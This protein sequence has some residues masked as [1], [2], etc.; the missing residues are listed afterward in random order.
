MYTIAFFFKHLKMYKLNYL[1][2]VNVSLFYKKGCSYRLFTRL[3]YCLNII[4]DM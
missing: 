1:S 3:F 4:G 2:I